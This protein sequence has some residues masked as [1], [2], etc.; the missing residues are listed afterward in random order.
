MEQFKYWIEDKFNE[1]RWKWEDLDK[2]YKI[3]GAVVVVIIIAS[4]IGF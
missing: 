2:K 3:I 1:L 4:I